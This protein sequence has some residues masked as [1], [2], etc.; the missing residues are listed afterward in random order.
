MPIKTTY[1]YKNRHKQQEMSQQRN[2]NDSPVILPNGDQV[3]LNEQGQFHCTFGPAIIKRNSDYKFWFNN[4]V[5]YKKSGYYPMC[6]KF[7]WAHD[8]SEDPPSIVYPNGDQEWRTVY[9]NLHRS[10]GPAK[11]TA[12][13]N[14]YYHHG[15][16]I[17]GE[18]V[19]G[20]LR[21][22][23]VF[24]ERIRASSNDEDS[25]FQRRLRENAMFAERIKAAR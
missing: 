20:R 11:I 2:N 13:G 12:A 9:G 25:W 16:R 14:L 10:H 18:I 4:G 8:D 7:D 22:K 5:F 24:L 6:G 1:L 15:E 19:E 21:E 3:W 17:D 23:A